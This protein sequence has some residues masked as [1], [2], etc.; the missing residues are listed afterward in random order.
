MICVKIDKDKLALVFVSFAYCPLKSCW[1]FTKLLKQ[2]NCMDNHYELLYIV[3][4]K[5]TGEELQ[6]IIDGVT[7][8]IKDNN[9]TITKDD[10]LGKLKLAYP[11][12]KVYQGTYVVFEFD[13]PRQNLKEIDKQLK[14]MPE[15]LRH[16]IVAK[17]IKTKEE[18]EHEQQIQEKLLKRK[19]EELDQAQGVEKVKKQ[20]AKVQ[21]EEKK[22]EPQEQAALTLQSEPEK[23]EVKEKKSPEKIS[24]DDLDKKL[25]EI[26]TDD[27][28]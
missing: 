16:L 26:L 4:V 18:I 8:L 1:L 10:I 3:S 2:A 5:H 17:K 15:V 19:Q 12:K 6:K 9:G 24:L 25:D 22:Q 13:L 7:K 21:S 20:S 27:V 23:V 11:I 14:L 28:I